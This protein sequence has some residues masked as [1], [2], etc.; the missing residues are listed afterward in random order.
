M[1]SLAASA[2]QDFIKDS[3]SSARLEPV[4]PLERIFHLPT[5]ECVASRAA[6]LNPSLPSTINASS[7]YR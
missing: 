6:L 4:N 1:A 7:S 5:I 2:A 3:A